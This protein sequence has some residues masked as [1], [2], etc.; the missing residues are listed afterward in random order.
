M[1]ATGYSA[2]GLADISNIDALD[3]NVQHPYEWYKR[4]LRDVHDIWHVL[5]GYSPDEPLDESCLVAFSYGQT[6]GL[7]WAVIAV[8]S[9]LSR[10]KVENGGLQIAAIWE[11]FRNGRKAKWLPGEDYEKL[12]AEPLDAA[13]ERLNIQAPTRL[14]T[15]RIAHPILS[16]VSLA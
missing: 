4:R 6:K 3:E 5:T 13:R 8:L 14:N 2:A 1:E 16:R 15:Y 12:L 10:L 11:A 9:V 7:G